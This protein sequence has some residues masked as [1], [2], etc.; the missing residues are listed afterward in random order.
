MRTTLMNYIVT[1][2]EFEYYTGE[3]FKLLKDGD[4]KVKTYKIYDL[5]DAATAHRDLEGRG[6]TGKLLLKL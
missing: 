6:T 3:L 2:E 4:L 5:K 1:R